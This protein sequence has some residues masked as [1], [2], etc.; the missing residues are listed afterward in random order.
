[1][2]LETRELLRC[3]AVLATRGGQHKYPT[4]PNPQFPMVS[5]NNSLPF[6]NL[7][8]RFTLTLFVSAP[9]A[10]RAVLTVKGQLKDV[11]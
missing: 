5:T 4:H 7:I 6:P 2:A 9:P 1:M 10:V 3:C 8:L 11:I